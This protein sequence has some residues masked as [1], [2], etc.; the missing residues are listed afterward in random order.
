MGTILVYAFSALVL[1]GVAVLA[2]SMGCATFFRL[3][4]WYR[5]IGDAKYTYDSDGLY[6]HRHPQHGGY[7]V[8]GFLVVKPVHETGWTTGDLKW[9]VAYDG[10]NE[11]LFWTQ[12]TRTPRRIPTRIRDNDLES[13]RAVMIDLDRHAHPWRYDRSV[14]VV[15][16][17]HHRNVA[18]TFLESSRRWR[19][20]ET[21]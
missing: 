20:D 3:R 9:A 2:T 5:I 8:R 1:A 15:Q 14:E 7:R 6:I 18:S 16:D 10:R 19:A 4:R 11:R 13:F 21:E 12:R 17:Q